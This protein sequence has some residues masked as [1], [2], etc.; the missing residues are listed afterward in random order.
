MLM[1]LSDKP[2]EAQK[3]NTFTEYNRAGESG[4][5]LFKP[6]LLEHTHFL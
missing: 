6:Y 2:D 1:L 5:H 4:G 3:S